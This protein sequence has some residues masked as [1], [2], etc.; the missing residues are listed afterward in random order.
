[1][2]NPLKCI[3]FTPMKNPFLVRWKIFTSQSFHTIDLI[4]WEGWEMIVFFHL[5]VR[6][7]HIRFVKWWKLF[8]KLVT[9]Q[10]FRFVMFKILEKSVYCPPS[11]IVLVD[12]WKIFTS[13]HSNSIDFILWERWETILFFHVIVRFVHIRF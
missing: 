13:Q 11:K 4:L 10:P 7:V 9:I 3:Y 1:M 2:R 8:S 5:I 6:F 12:D